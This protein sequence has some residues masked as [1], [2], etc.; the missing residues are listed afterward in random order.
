[1]AAT[2]AQCVTS[3]GA[4]LAGTLRR[5][6]IVD[7]LIRRLQ[8]TFSPSEVAVALHHEDG[9]AGADLHTWPAGATD[10]APL[11]DAAGEGGARRIE[12]E[13]AIWCLAPLMAR[14]RITGA[15]VMR[16]PAGPFAPVAPQ[17]LEA[18]A[19]QASVAIESAY[20]VDLYDDGR[21]SWQEIVDALALALCI[22]D[23][24]G[25]IRRANR[26]FA[27]L[28]G[29]PPAGLVGRPWSAFLP[30]DWVSDVQRLLDAA[31]TGGEAELTTGDRTYCV[32]AVPITE[33]DA[34]TVVV[35]FDDH[36]ERRRLQDKLVQSTK[37]SAMGQLVAGVAHELNNP[38][39]SV[40]GFADF[41]GEIP[42]VPASL[43]EPL[44][45]IREEAERASSIVR[46]LLGFAR[47]QDR[48]R[49]LTALGPL[50]ES[51]MSL[52]RNPLMASRVES[53]IDIEPDLP[54]ISIDP[55]QM[56]Q[57]LV[58]LVSN[59]AQAI[60]STGRAGTVTVRARRFL[61]E[62]AVDIVDDGPG[63]TAEIA[64]QVFDPFF[65]TKSEHEG[66]GLGISI[67]QGIV[68]EH[69]GRITL[70]TAPDQGA[71]FTIHLPLQEAPADPVRE[72][73]ARA[74]AT[75]LRVL[76]VDD[77]PH[78]LHYMSATLSAWG[79]TVAVAQDGDEGLEAAT[80]GE[81]DLVITDLRMPRLSGRDF[82]ET[83][84]RRN[85][86]MASR[87]YFSTG[88]TVRG[89]TLAFLEMLERPY[90]HK[91]FS[92]AELREL[93]AAA[94]ARLPSPPEPRVSFGVSTDR[95]S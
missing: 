28:V 8:D 83:L 93:L 45:V 47:K 70:E 30:P 84:R 49:R 71:T 61:D 79:H 64:A 2:V 65:T 32:S 75:R 23:R 20:L 36:T 16:D 34:S 81:F 48:Q 78:I 63:M 56:Q 67:S 62:L 54:S 11:L 5:G 44:R 89:D 92:L 42:D 76:V 68:R 6:P 13:G 18:F 24:E 53:R 29:A 14:R 87:L 88:D 86:A 21:R 15:V 59:A 51:T 90:L 46:N 80:S 72:E 25:R 19:A 4:E 82:F 17:L 52:L 60:A 55:N 41:L 3:F 9:R 33:G 95:D 40:V 37:L 77:E 12:H 1:M 31:G 22:V 27:A 38:L 66:T 73:P 94:T 57:V 7:L 91:P 35:L 74:P 85:P 50:I 69:G 58:N 39:A 10:V 26:A 43:R